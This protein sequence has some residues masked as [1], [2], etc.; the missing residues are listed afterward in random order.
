MGGGVHLWL[1]GSNHESK[2][3]EK[4]ERSD[5]VVYESTM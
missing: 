2:G 3:R 5:H 1:S 4:K